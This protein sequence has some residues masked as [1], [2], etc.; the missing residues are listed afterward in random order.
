MVK[1]EKEVLL[2]IDS[3]AL[4]H[5][6]FHAFKPDLTTSN[7]EVVNAVYGFTR[8]LLEVLTKFKP[9][10]VIAA[11]DSPGPTV[12]HNLYGQY[13]ATRKPTDNLL[14]SQIPR[15]VELLS[16]FGIP[17]LLQP[18][19]EAD[20]IIGTL[21]LNHSG[22]D[23]LTIIVTGDRDLYQLVD[24]DTKVYM[25]G[26]A[27]SESK[28]YDTD[29]VTARMGVTPAQIVDFKAI[30]GDASDNIPGVAGIGEKGAQG[31]LAEFH[32]LDNIYINIDKVAPRHQEKLKAS[33]EMA[34]KS[35]EL[36]T[37]ICDAPITFDLE[38]ALFG[39]FNVN[40]TVKLFQE[41]EFRSLLLKPAQLK[42]VYA[43]EEVLQPDVALA[44][45]GLVQPIDCIDYTNQDLTLAPEVVVAFEVNVEGDPLTWT[46]SS[47]FIE[48]AGSRYKMLDNLANILSALSK[49]Q[50]IITADAKVLLH[51]FKNN[52]ITYTGEVYDVILAEYLISEGRSIQTLPGSA[53]SARIGAT[54]ILDAVSQ[55]YQSHKT[56]LDD[57]LQ[58]AQ[59]VQL[60][61]KLIPVIVDME[62]A[63]ITLDAE[64]LL[65]YQDK[66]VELIA[67]KEKDIYYNVGHEFN[68]SS[69]KQVGQVLFEELSLPGLRKTKTGGYS[70]DERTLKELAAAHPAIPQI[71]DYR[72]LTKLLSTYVKPLPLLINKQTQRLHTNYKQMGAVTGR[73]AS[74]NPNLQNIPLGEVEGINMRA[75]FVAAPDTV[76]VSFDYS[77]QELR[78]LAEFS[79][80]EDMMAAFASGIDIHAATAAE[81]FDIPVT[82][83]TKEQRKVGKTINFGVVYGISA[84]GLADRLKID[85]RKA[86]GFIRKYFETYPKIKLYY[87]QLLDNAKAEGYVSTLLGRRRGA[88]DLVSVNAHLR[89]AVE[90]EVQNFPLQGSAADIIKSAMVALNPKLNKYPVKMLLQVHDELVFEYLAPNLEALK[91]D[92]QFQSFIKE[93][94]STM[95]DVV[96]TKV[97]FDVGIEYGH[98]WAQMQ[99]WS[100]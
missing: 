22:A 91:T 40:N 90:R 18:G 25:A 71:L 9:K 68:I 12:R 83:V 67:A 58:L 64:L 100:E 15:I 19:Y 49:V 54:N 57:Q 82:E 17:V 41:L 84:F 85:N 35:Q 11:M 26:S 86:A 66:L 32:N 13:K 96:K 98:N 38:D 52:Q 45:G 31:L 87:T 23:N 39:G 10:Y 27:F 60:E 76:L 74:L 99:E 70:T 72:E 59:I 36:A 24:E 37:I 56:K 28:L 34:Y 5:R 51:A 47:L 93:V 62:Q 61:N 75:S 73:F 29:A 14:T 50:T 3:Y 94:K 97:P 89:Q 42:Q 2:L 55:L 63:G 53:S 16:A 69:P 80:E 43:A 78:L 30:Q 1:Q 65:K 48:A 95:L 77:Q 20:D 33:M 46:L 81:M 6:A 79:K 44:A 7:G 8:L 4:I 92:A 88:R 21:D